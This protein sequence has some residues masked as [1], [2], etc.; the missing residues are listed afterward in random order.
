MVSGD[1]ETGE[2]DNKGGVKAYE[3]GGGGGSGAGWTSTVAEQQERCC[4][5]DRHEE[6]EGARVHGHPCSGG[7]GGVG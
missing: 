3:G 5:G 6:G 2:A 4:H 7:G 1:E